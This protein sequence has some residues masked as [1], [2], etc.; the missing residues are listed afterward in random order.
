MIITK[1]FNMQ[2]KK[3]LE[4][5][6]DIKD[7]NEIFSNNIE[8]MLMDKL[9]EKFIGKCY[10]SC[11]IININ[12]IIKRSF[13]YMKDTLEGDCHLNIMFEVDAIEYIKNEIINGC[14]IIKKESNG[15]I[16]AISEHTGIQI[17]IPANISIFKEG[18]IIP[19]IVKMVRY[20]INQTS[21]SVLA[22][23]FIPNTDPI[24][25]YKITDTLSKPETE[26]INSLLSQIKNAELNIKGDSNSKKIYKFFTDMLANNNSS[27]STINNNYKKLFSDKINQINISDILNIKTGIV[28][29]S[30]E[31]FDSS[32]I[33][34]VKSNDKIEDKIEDIIEESMFII[35]STLL[36]SYLSNIQ[37]LQGFLKYYSKIED[38][39]KNKSIWKLYT[40]MK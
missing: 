3:L 35:F 23:P 15:I 30:N 28:F 16:H 10:M 32:I 8:N 2:I 6:I 21:V 18:D 27:K 26:I 14:K 37:S 33:M 24:I 9:R 22:T 29:K 13:I 7:T 34:N 11:L 38:I 4:T 19:V 20:N 5:Y 31:E 17:N 39:K 1:T 25:Y 40:S 36:I 12:K